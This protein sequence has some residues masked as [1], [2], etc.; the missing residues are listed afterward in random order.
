[1]ASSGS[2]D[3]TIV[4]VIILLIIGLFAYAYLNKRRIGNKQKELMKA[5][6]ASPNIVKDKPIFIQGQAQAPDMILPTTGE[7]VVYYGLF[8]M[9]KE[10]TIRDTHSGVGIRVNGIPLGTALGTEKDHIDSVQGFHF[11][12]T[13]GDFTVASGSAYYFVRPSGIIAYFKKG[14]DL[15]A[16]FIGGQFEKTGLPR[17]FFDD[18]MAFQVA[19]QALQMFCGFNAPMIEERSRRFSGGWTKQTTTQRTTVSVTTATARIDARVHEFM[20]GYNIPQGIADLLAKRM[21]E[22]PDKEGIIAIEVYIPL[23]R[24]VY[25]FGTFDGDRSIIFGDTDV[26]LSVSYTDPETT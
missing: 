8:V 5:F 23:N 19:Q 15:V 9:S 25:V 21:I 22:L 10:T 17:S 18:A 7:H 13:S 12:E 16:G 1:M 2:G 11:Y 3:L 14:A 26:Q 20:A 4:V 24:A 6:R